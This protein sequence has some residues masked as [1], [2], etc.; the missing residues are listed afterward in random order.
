MSLLLERPHRSLAIAALYLTFALL[1]AA[2]VAQSR[3]AS[4]PA[5]VVRAIYAR[6]MAGTE[7]SPFSEITEEDIDALFSE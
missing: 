5:S 2:A 6:M 3:S 4:P 7:A 1:P